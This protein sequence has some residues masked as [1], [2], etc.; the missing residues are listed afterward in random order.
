MGNPITVNSAAVK[1]GGVKHLTNA[2]RN[3]GSPISIKTAEA[4]EQ[5]SGDIAKVANA[6]T[7]LTVIVPAP[8]SDD[9]VDYN[10]DPVTY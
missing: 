4:I 9:S 2:I 7:A 3:G 6:L 5:Q 10:N 8:I 1:L